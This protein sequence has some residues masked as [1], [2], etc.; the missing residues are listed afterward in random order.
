MSGTDAPARVA[1]VSEIQAAL[2]AVR[3]GQFADPARPTALVNEAPA[4]GSQADQSLRVA[5]PMPSSS[6]SMPWVPT[7]A[8]DLPP[9]SGRPGVWLLGVHGGSGAR[10]LSAVL[11]ATR[12]AGRIW[13][14]STSS[15]REPVVLVCRGNHRGLTAVQ[16]YARAYRDQR[17]AERLQLLGVIVS[18]DAPGRTPTPL[19]RLERLL[20]GAVPILGHAPWEPTWR[21][22]PPV[23]TDEPPSWLAKLTQSLSAAAGVP[24]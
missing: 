4:A 6:A 19:R 22:G 11:P 9:A 21:L 15:P 16:D 13:P 20:S 10:C 24:S 7:T 1:S 3:A 8:A 12:Y 18:A 23:A 2:R 14:T 17:L 5:T